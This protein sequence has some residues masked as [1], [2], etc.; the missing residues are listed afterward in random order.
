MQLQDGVLSIDDAIGDEMIEEFSSTLSQ[1]G[2]EKIEVLTNDLG[3]SIVQTLLIAQR[4][5]TV[6]VHDPVLEKIF[7]NVCYITVDE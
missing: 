1:E 5:I 2:I 6:E 4:E 7:E 3:G